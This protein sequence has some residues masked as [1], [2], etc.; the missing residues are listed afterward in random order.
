[1]DAIDAIKSIEAIVAE[2]KH[3][4]DSFDENSVLITKQM[5]DFGHIIINQINDGISELIKNNNL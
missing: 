4:I 5:K 1:M 2:A 3:D